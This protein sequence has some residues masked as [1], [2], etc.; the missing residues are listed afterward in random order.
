MD[1]VKI[2]HCADLHIGAAQTILGE[3]GLSR[4]FEALITF[5]NIIKLAREKNVK[6]ILIAGDLFCSNSVERS[7]VNSVLECISGVPGTEVVFS[8]GN[9][10]PYNTSSPFFGAVLP[11]NFHI[12][13]D[14][15]A[16]IYFDKLNTKVYGR[17]FY[18][19]YMKGE[20]RFTLP[21]DDKTINIM[22]QHGEIKSDLSSNY[23]SITNEFIDTCGMD[24]IALG[25]VHKRSPIEKRRNTYFAYCGCA[26]GLGF[27]ETGDKGVYIGDVGKGTLE[28]EFYKT[29]IRTHEKISV[30]VSS[31]RDNPAAADEVMRILS[32]KYGEG[33]ADNLY[34][35]TLTGDIP[36]NGFFDIKEIESR[37]SQ[38]LYFVKLVDET[39]VS[40]DLEVLKNEKSLK[41]VFVSKMLERIA[42]NPDDKTLT[43]ALNIGLKAF[44]SEVDYYEDN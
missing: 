34:K 14:S 35:I 10:D 12:L 30:D 31:C 4:R 16:V 44:S 33:F 39:G 11:K 43:L 6:L 24:Y 3:K 29:S 38:N 17:S 32:E 36:E 9:H 37:L 42:A 40:R 20:P 21:A 19:V 23:N 26:E 41:G 7:A 1:T 28:L 27:D 22:C 25:H 5:E 8:A 18:D 13:P 15:D 2:L